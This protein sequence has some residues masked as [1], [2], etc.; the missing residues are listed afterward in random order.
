MG[1]HA[2]VHTHTHTHTCT[3][4]T[5]YFYVNIFS[6]LI[7]NNSRLM[8]TH[9]AICTALFCKSGKKKF[10]Y[11]LEDTKTFFL[12][13]FLHVG[14]WYYLVSGRNAL[15]VFVKKKKKKWGRAQLVNHLF[16]ASCPVCQVLDRRTCTAT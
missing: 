4:I 8:V 1:G 9:T 16:S 5:R 3:I 13:L 6:S 2:C 14:L 7:C 10:Q 11:R 15:H 12:Q